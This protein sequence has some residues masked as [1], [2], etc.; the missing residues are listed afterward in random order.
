MIEYY[1]FNYIQHIN[2]ISTFT[3]TENK[4]ILKGLSGY[5][6]SGELNAI[7]GPSGAGK[8]TLLNLLSGYT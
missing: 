8:S 5:F 6:R 4:D 2:S 1:L 7:A 3:I